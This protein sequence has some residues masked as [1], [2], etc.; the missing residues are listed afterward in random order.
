MLYLRRRIRVTVGGD[1]CSQVPGG[2]TT[3]QGSP[4]VCSPARLEVGI[5]ATRSHFTESHGGRR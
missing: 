1:R 5:T 4:S 2:A 3:I